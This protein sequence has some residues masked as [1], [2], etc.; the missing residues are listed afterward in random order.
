VPFIFANGTSNANIKGANI[1]NV[2]VL[3]L[4][5]FKFVEIN[6]CG[7]WKLPIH[8][9]LGP[10]KLTGLC[11]SLRPDGDVCHQGRDTEIVPKI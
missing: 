2:M 7:F 9:N 4:K 1:F 6:G 11:N 3:S 10:Q 8:R 5:I